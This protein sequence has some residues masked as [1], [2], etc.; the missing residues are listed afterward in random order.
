MKIFIWFLIAWCFI[1][2]IGYIGTAVIVYSDA[3][4]C[5]KKRWPTLD[6]S[7]PR[8]VSDV[9]F[10]ALLWPFDLPAILILRHKQNNGLFCI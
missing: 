6:L 7:V 4:E 3:Y 8:M 1:Y 5:Y 10:A 9:S 2:P